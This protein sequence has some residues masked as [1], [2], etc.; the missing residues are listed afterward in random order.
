VFEE[1]A[2]AQRV[3]ERL[4]SEYAG[5]VVLQPVLWEHEPL[6][7]SSTFQEQI[8]R[9]SETDVVVSILWSRLGTRLPKGFT[10]EDGSRYDSGTEYEFEDAIAAYR[11]N[12]K[13]DLLVYRK[14]A[15]P[16]VRL[17]DEKELLERLQQ[18][19]KLDE[20]VSRWFHD[21]AE[22]TLIA[23]FH[24]FDSPSD[25]ESLLEA[26]LHKLIERKLPN[27]GAAAGEAPAVWKK[28]SPFRGLHAFEFEHAPIFFGRTKAVSDIL[29]GLRNQAA[30]GRSFILVLG[31]SG[32]GKSSVV[33][34][35]VLPMLTQPG[36]I[37]G[38]ALWRRAI[39]RPGDTPGDLFT[40][41][42]SALLRDH[43][44][45]AL[46]SESVGPA[47]LAQVLRDSPQSAVMLIKSALD[48]AAAGQS[49]A[50]PGDGRIQSR[51]AL[52]I[53]QMEEMFTQEGI[54]A[55]ERKAFANTLDA[56]AR[57]GRVWII[58]TLRSDFY[59]RLSDIPAIGALKDGDGQYDLMPPVASEIGQM[60]RL[61][62]RAAGLRFEED[63]A[64]SERLDDI[65]RDAAA[66]RPEILPLLQFT[67]EELYQRRTPDGT[68]TL[69]AYRELG[70][71][72]GSLAQRAE[73][74]FLELPP[75]VQAALPKVLNAL[76]SIEQDGHE[77]IGRKRA[78]WKDATNPQVRTLLET[79]V[80]AR[81]FVTELADDGGAVVT[82]SHE[83]LLWH[84]PRVSEWV[85]QNR[86]NLR[87]RGRISVA[88]ERWAGDQRPSDLLLPRGKPLGE[89]ETLLEHDIDLNVIEADFINASM[90]KARRTQQLK[91]AV[92]VMLAFL[93]IT[94][95]SA[96]FLA[97]EQRNRA[98]EA[99][100]RAEVEAETARRTTEFMVGLFEVSDPSEALGNT[101]TAREIMDRGADRIEAELVEQ[102][103]IQATLMETMGTVYTS[104]ALYAQA[105]SLLERALTLR[106]TVFGDK[107]LEVARTWD[108]LGQVLTRQA[109]YAK[110]DEALRTAL[111]IR[112]ELHGDEHLE[113]AESLANLA[114]LKTRTG[115]FEQAEPLLRQ[116]L[117]MRTAI[118]GAEHMEVAQSMEQLGLNMFDQGDYATAESMLRDSISMRKKLLKGNQ[119][120]QLAQGL[121]NLASV[122][123][124]TGNFKDAQS[125][126]QEALDIN[127]HM[128][129]EYHPT[130]AVNMNNLAVLY[131]DSGEF[132]SAEAMYRDVIEIRE[133][134][135]GSEH[136]EVAL[137]MSNLAYLLYDK[138]DSEA[139]MSL[140]RKAIDKYRQLFPLGH[141]D[142]ASSLGALGSWLTNAERYIEAEPLLRE[143]V[144][145]RERIFG[146]E[147]IQVAVGKTA[148][149]QLYLA[150]GRIEDAERAA[151]TAHQ[152]LATQLPEDHWRTAWAAS[153]EGSSLAQ[154]KQFDEAEG[155]LL[156][157]LAILRQ[158][159]GSGS[160]T[161]YVEKTIAYLADLYRN[162]G[163]SE[164]AAVY[165]AMLNGTARR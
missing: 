39:F 73:T 142:L 52:V 12:G 71:V 26:H 55:K 89:A 115:E 27:I 141:P 3:I 42:A 23:A 47:N 156:K 113:T 91:G 56:L 68:L 74:V 48:Q 25:F 37:E 109:D 40:G 63:F 96:A 143:S 110:A 145:M 5:R 94:A 13:P 17:D 152:V 149:A 140:Q 144:E 133:K 126:Y 66:E 87:I 151:R 122:L 106:R 62:T 33:R 120:P 18:K 129:D 137:A 44:L 146:E 75:E 72:E 83:A 60:I 79:F 160:R 100:S 36:V 30:D 99:Q 9:P 78:P 147:H 22:G 70:G 150:T 6:V 105:E 131:H 157:S 10:R 92:F 117:E 84:W 102:P 98:I 119:N 67:L 61:P 139:A 77:S 29:Q 16:S 54:N 24:A 155:L 19:K 43:G 158:G 28:G 153:L 134:S 125:M 148:L 101:I 45:P 21:K 41:L 86:E 108:R 2:I 162:W 164:E 34:A 88:A 127:Q 107:H 82:V 135:L 121:N 38:V 1:R 130:I 114:E 85:D 7:A 165:L 50:V 123:A 128:L 31:M 59:P 51:L 163:K 64:S 124:E 53:D 136:P 80:A 14:T 112:Q 57:C 161:V 49:R 104:L 118:L 93:T 97:S 35:G 69:E 81:L 159:P 154:R 116:A 90:A 65:L 20:F 76:V 15:P 4:Q 132:D 95:G 103:R 46:D 11:K 138:G 58:G 32:G 111:A 8:I